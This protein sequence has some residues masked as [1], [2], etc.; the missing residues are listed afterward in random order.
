MASHFAGSKTKLLSKAKPF[1]R[2]GRSH[3]GNKHTDSLSR[4]HVDQYSELNDST[5]APRAAFSSVH[6]RIHAPSH[7]DLEE[8][9]IMK[10]LSVEQSAHER[11]GV[12]F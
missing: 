4:L 7:G 2:S 12:N 8:G 10:S 9:I 3:F 11:H 1:P 5:N 6:T